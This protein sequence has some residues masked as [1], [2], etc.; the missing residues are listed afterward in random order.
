MNMAFH[1]VSLFAMAIC[2][3]G[4]STP[5]PLEMNW[6]GAGS[7]APVP[8]P[9][10]APTAPLTVEEAVCRAIACSTRLEAMRA[11]LFVAEQRTRAASDITDPELG[12]GWGRSINDDFRYRTGT[13]ESTSTSTSTGR[14]ITTQTKDGTTSSSDG[15]SSSSSSSQVKTTELT[16]SSRSSESRSLVTAGSAREAGD[17]W[18]V[19]ARVF[20][21]NP[22][23]V[24]PRVDARKAETWAAQA[25]LQ[26]ATWGLASEVRRWFAEVNFVSGDLALATRQAGFCRDISDTVRTRA[27]QGAATSLEVMA[28]AQRHIQAL[29]DLDQTRHRLK[30]AQRSLAAL[31]NVPPDALG[32][33]TNATPLSSVPELA[34]TF[35]Q[36]EQ[37]AQ[38]RRGDIVA[39]QWRVMAARAAY[40]EV[41][42][43]RLPWV[44]EINAS[45]R[46][47]RGQ[48]WGTDTTTGSGHGSSSEVRS[49][50]GSGRDQRTDTTSGGKVS[51]TDEQI[52]EQARRD[53][54]GTSSGSEYGSTVTAD[55]GESEEWFVGFVV[56]IPIFSWVKN[57][58]DDVLLAQYK[59]ALANAIEG[60]RTISREIRDALDELKE[61]GQQLDRYTREVGPMVAAMRQ[62]HQVLKDTPHSMPDKVAAAELQIIESLR[63]DLGARWRYHLAVIN[64]ERVL[65]A[66]L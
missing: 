42:N 23:I 4:C 37:K 44:K 26:A 61:R 11:A 7:P 43:M 24:G 13:R 20:V 2:L 22:W 50:T 59:L 63:L 51:T 10:S 49:S 19:S 34:I 1:S 35:E 56:D 62:S 28:A 41:R 54:R 60:R 27:E 47:S 17:G 6:V 65:G 52:D 66:S 30:L 58:G 3:A 25:D 14:E 5:A 45:Y 36:A 55:Q 32:V 33:K 12:F 38:Q 39:L 53:S 16:T 64:L 46:S 8:P 15:S 57:H 29:D 18:K 31:L 40:R 9:Q 48:T 21:P